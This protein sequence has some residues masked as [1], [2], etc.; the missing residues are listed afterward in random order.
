MKR[1]LL[2]GLVLIPTLAW[3]T[4]VQAQNPA[5]VQK[6]LTTGECPGCDLRGADLSG[7][8]LIGADLR[9]AKLQ[10]ANLK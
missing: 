4:L 3:G 5:Q 1:L 10:G 7:A 2:T 6:L 8:H 9:N